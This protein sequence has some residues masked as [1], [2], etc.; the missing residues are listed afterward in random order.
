V[1]GNALFGG[2][3]HTLMSPVVLGWAF[4]RLSFPSAFRLGWS[5]PFPG[6]SFGFSRYVAAVLTVDH[7]L[8]YIDTKIFRLPN[9][10]TAVFQGNIPQ[11]PG[12]AIP[13]VVIVCGIAL[14][15]LRATDFRVCL[16][17]LGTVFTLAMGCH[18]LFPAFSQH[19]LEL[20]IGNLLFAAFFI[21]ANRRIAPKTKGGRWIIGILTGT[22]AFLF[23]Y[24]SPFSEGVFFAI[25]VGNLCSRMI[26][27]RILQFKYRHII[28]E[29]E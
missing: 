3:G 17:F 16:S 20:C 27:E 9:P 8:R 1:I 23:R 29:H 10:I 18:Y 11:T 5:L 7:P 4:A 24:V 13:S 26:D 28:N 25:L 21:I 6:V 12:N 22:V 19:I 2:Y 14:L 15:L